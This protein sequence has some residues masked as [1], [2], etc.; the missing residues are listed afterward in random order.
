MW[1]EIKKTMDDKF[2]DDHLVRLHKNGKI[3]QAIKI[4]H[5]SVQKFPR[6]GTNHCWVGWFSDQKIKD[7]SQALKYGKHSRVK[8]SQT[9]RTLTNLWN[10]F[11]SD[12]VFDV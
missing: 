2:Y 4:C 7:Q 5:Q 10:D 9:S 12:L 3:E 11:F 1:F 6:S 8:T